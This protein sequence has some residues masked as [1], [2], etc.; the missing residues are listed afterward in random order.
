MKP[1][2]VPTP[3]DN[4]CAICGSG[5]KLCF[6]VYKLLTKSMALGTHNLTVSNRN[7]VHL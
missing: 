5:Q 2:Q 1:L 6:N 7:V 3:D 4:V